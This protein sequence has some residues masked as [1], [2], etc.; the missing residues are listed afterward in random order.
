MTGARVF[1]YDY[2]PAN[3]AVAMQSALQQ[4]GPLTVAIAIANSFFSYKYGKLSKKLSRLII[5][6]IQAQSM[7][8]NLILL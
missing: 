8:I 6:K 2:A 5:F 3:D 1:R 4:Y 7:L